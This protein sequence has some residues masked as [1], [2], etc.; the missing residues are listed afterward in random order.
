MRPVT[1]GLAT[2]AGA[3]AAGTA[4][5]WFHYGTA[6]FYETILAGLNACF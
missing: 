4:A 2:G 6:V 1:M 3:L 5:L